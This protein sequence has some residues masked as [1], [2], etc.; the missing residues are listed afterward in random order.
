MGTSLSEE[1]LSTEVGSVQVLRAGSGDP[2]VYLHSAMGEGA[3]MLVLE[4]LAEDRA[5]VAPVFPGFGESEGI[6][7]IEDMEDAVFHL[8]DVFD[9]P[10]DEFLNLLRPIG[11]EFVQPFRAIDLPRRLHRLGHAV[12]VDQP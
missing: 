2:V 5:V 8:L 10:F 4:D 6:E 1:R 12:G 11:N 9:H 3:G 7:R